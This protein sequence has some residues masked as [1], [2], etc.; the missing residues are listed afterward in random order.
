M[1][2]KDNDAD[3]VYKGPSVH[4]ALVDAVDCVV[5]IAVTVWVTVLVTAGAIAV[6]LATYPTAPPT[7]RPTTAPP[8]TSKNFRRETFSFDIKTNDGS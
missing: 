3:P 4:R 5:A 2:Q 8:A 1:F 6:G 7:T